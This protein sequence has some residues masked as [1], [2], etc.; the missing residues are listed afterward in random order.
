MV[1]MPAVF[2]VLILSQYAPGFMAGWDIGRAAML[3]RWGYY[4]G[5]ITESE[6]VGILWELSQKV[7]EELHI[8]VSARQG[9]ETPERFPHIQTTASTRTLSPN[10]ISCTPTCFFWLKLKLTIYPFFK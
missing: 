5:W 1:R 9:H 3:T 4:L 8:K 7:V 6:A 10:T 2:S